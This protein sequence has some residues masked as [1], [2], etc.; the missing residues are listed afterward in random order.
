MG[1]ERRSVSWT[2]NNRT[3]IDCF[4]EMMGVGLL[5]GSGRTSLEFASMEESERCPKV[6]GEMPKSVGIVNWDPVKR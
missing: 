3:S 4:A 5:R 2:V 6:F 1:N